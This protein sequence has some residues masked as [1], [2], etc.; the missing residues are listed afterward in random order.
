M[1][2]DKQNRK[3]SLGLK[4]SLFPEGS[5]ESEVTE[6]E[7]EDEDVDEYE[8]DALLLDQD[9]LDDLEDDEQDQESA[10]ESED[11]DSDSVSESEGIAEQVSPNLDVSRVYVVSLSQ[12]FAYAVPPQ[13]RAKPVNAKSLSSSVGF[14]WNGGAESEDEDNDHRV[15]DDD[16]DVEEALE[17]TQATTSATDLS[18]LQD[19]TAELDT[20]VPK[21]VADFERLV[22]GSPNSSY[23]WIQ[24]IAFFVGLSQLDKARETGRR[25]LKTINFRD[26]QEKLNVWVALL[27]LE[28]S[29]G[30]EQS[31][32]D[33]F[34]EAVQRN[35]A[36]TIHLRLI[37]IY[38][39]SGKTEVS[40]F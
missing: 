20:A 11:D 26:E 13:E 30:S 36:K 35:D 22:L 37:D 16:S 19:R 38:E 29:Y 2:V 6:A 14:Q 8:E 3:V 33:L 10:S 7:D 9:M 32:D 23:L 21:S 31:L 4:R 1:D 27:N 25:A 17:A 24:F 34:K 5:L 12:L 39:R 15:N 40:R 18:G 28:N